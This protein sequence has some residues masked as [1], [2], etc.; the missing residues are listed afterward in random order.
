MDKIDLKKSKSNHIIR[1]AAQAFAQR[2]YAGASVAEIAIQAGIG[3]GTVYEY[4]QSKDDLF[5]AVFEWYVYKTSKR[6]KINI[7]ALG[8]SAT[9]RLEAL[10]AAVINLWDE[11]SDIF[12]LTMEFWSASSASTH[13]NR[14][15]AAFKDLYR[16]LRT[17]VASL[18]QDG[19]GR[20]EFNGD[21]D[22]EAV[23]AALVGTWDALFLQAWFD[24]EFRPLHTA[25]QFFKVVIRGLK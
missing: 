9:Q 18:I 22:V 21:V 4:F 25:Q 23:A 14:I 5:F 16:N 10:N 24:S 11:I 13:R 6:L 1:A 12:A 2:G 8:G 3:K 17:I 7:S 20:G 15:K 19:I